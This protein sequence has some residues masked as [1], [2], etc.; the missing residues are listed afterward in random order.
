M[1]V[2]GWLVQGRVLVEVCVSVSVVFVCAWVNCCVCVCCSFRGLTLLS[3]VNS[4]PYKTKNN[5]AEQRK[6]LARAA[7]D[8][9]KGRG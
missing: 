6:Q 5:E 1:V 7:P 9:L 3:G 8:L 2:S 4:L